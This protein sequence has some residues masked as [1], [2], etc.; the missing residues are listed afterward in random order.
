MHP[1]L[2]PIAGTSLPGLFVA[3]LVQ[4]TVHL[5]WLWAVIVAV[6]LGFA[7]LAH[8][9][10]A[11]FVG[12]L[13]LPVVVVIV[14]LALHEAGH[15][16][17]LRLRSR[18][19][20]AGRLLLGVGQLGIVR[21]VFQAPRDEVLVA[22]AGPLLS[23]SIGLAATLLGWVI[24]AWLLAACGL[25]LAAHVF[26]LGPWWSDGRAAVQAMRHG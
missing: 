22:C 12:A 16:Y 23:F 25:L 17:V 15:L 11:V 8:L 26:C 1:R 18:D 5:W 13:A 4:I 10:T 7:A 9:L 20:G 2:H 3:I 14:G 19:P 6:D 24:H 21:P